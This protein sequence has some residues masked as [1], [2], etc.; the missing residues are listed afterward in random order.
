[1]DNLSEWRVLLRF[2][3]GRLLILLQ[4]KSAQKKPLSFSV[5]SLAAWWVRFGVVVSA[6]AINGFFLRQTSIQS[7][8]SAASTTNKI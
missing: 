2:V 6:I 7:L 5:S 8:R 3:F 1:M 4:E